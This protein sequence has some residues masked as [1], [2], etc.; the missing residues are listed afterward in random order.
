MAARLRAFPWI[1]HLPLPSIQ[2]QGDIKGA[3]EPLATEVIESAKRNANTSSI[4][5]KDLLS[6]LRKFKLQVLFCSGIS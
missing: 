1:A 3:V 6:I 4:K 2:A 5:G